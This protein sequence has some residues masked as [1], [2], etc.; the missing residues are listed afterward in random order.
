MNNR[1]SCD[2]TS[3]QLISIHR[4]FGTAFFLYLHVPSILIRRI[5][6]CLFPEDGEGNRFGL[7]LKHGSSSKRGR[8]LPIDKVSFPRRRESSSIF[9][10]NPNLPYFARVNNLNLEAL[11][12]KNAV[13]RNTDPDFVN[14]YVDRTILKLHI[15]HVSCNA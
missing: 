11:H 3:S 12:D 2:V 6:D 9:Y 8:Y 13:A 14:R 15:K 4:R 10:D 7:K 1:V 5:V